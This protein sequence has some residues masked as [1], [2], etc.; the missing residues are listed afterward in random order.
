MR[1]GNPGAEPRGGRPSTQIYAWPPG[2]KPHSVTD[3][4]ANSTAVHSL[5]TKFRT[6]MFRIDSAMCAVTA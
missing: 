6:N 2:I 4:R 1:R 5:Y 3:L